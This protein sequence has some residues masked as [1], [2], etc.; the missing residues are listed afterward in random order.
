MIFENVPQRLFFCLRN[1]G[2]FMYHN[3]SQENSYQVYH[4]GKPYILSIYGDII[5]V[6]NVSKHINVDNKYAASLIPFK[7]VYIDPYD[8]IFALPMFLNEHTIDL[9]RLGSSEALNYADDNLCQAVSLALME[10]AKEII[11]S[12]GRL[13][14]SINRFPENV[15]EALNEVCE[16]RECKGDISRVLTAYGISRNAPMDESEYGVP[17]NIP[18]EEIQVLFDPNNVGN[19]GLAKAGYIP[20]DLENERNIPS[21]LERVAITETQFN[22]QNDPSI[23]AVMKQPTRIGYHVFYP[24]LR[25]VVDVDED[26]IPIEERKLKT[27]PELPVVPIL[28]NPIGYVPKK[29]K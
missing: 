25:T 19:R 20:E 15:Q 29:Q 18:L 24:A 11:P 6:N 2:Y 17:H 4:V 23:K 28:Q 3:P 7:V 1:N 10:L 8:N 12:S 26:I 14:S 13:Y 22:E 21:G 27:A 5:I 9:I 16:E